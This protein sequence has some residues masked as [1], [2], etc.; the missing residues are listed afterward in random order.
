M[1][2]IGTMNITRTRGQGDFHCPTCGSLREYSLKSRRPFLTLYFIPTVPIGAS[3]LFVRCDG[4]KSN[5]DPAILNMSARDHQVAKD[6]QF[7][8]EAFRAS[9]LVVLHGG[10]INDR[11][12][13]ALL[14]IGHR[15]LPEP[16]DR[17]DLGQLCSS[18]VQ[19]RVSAAN[20]VRSVC[21][22]W[23]IEQKQRALGA[24]FVAATADAGLD[25]KTLVLLASLRD[26]MNLTDEEYESA[27]EAA[28]QW[29]DAA[30]T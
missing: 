23:S 17:D 26:A 13:E 22:A 20:Y 25:A 24:M 3:E 8:V 27:I 9:V 16:I 10:A 29:D 11:E 4:C 30:E 14:E 1:I 6:T 2:L 28:I 5:W 7:R 19:N 21:R 18:A 12:I 15:I